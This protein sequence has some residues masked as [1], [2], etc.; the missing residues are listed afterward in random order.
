MQSE[1]QQQLSSHREKDQEA[2]HLFC[3]CSSN[4]AD[5]ILF[6]GRP[7]IFHSVG[8]AT[9]GVSDATGGVSDATRGTVLGQ[10]T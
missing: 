4:G 1:I 9:G 2:S 7:N 10:F 5:G 3:G 6:E 8:E